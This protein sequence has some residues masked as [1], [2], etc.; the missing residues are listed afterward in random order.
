MAGNSH[1]F[2]TKITGKEGA[3]FNDK[4]RQGQDSGERLGI[5]KS[6]QLVLYFSELPIISYEFSKGKGIYK[7]FIKT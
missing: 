5:T 4:S 7:K 2:C 3:H 1:E 6:T